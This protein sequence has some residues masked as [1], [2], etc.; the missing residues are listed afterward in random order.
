MFNRI[1]R[2][3]GGAITILSAFVLVAVV[4]VSA[5]AVEF[6]RG[7]YRRIENQR[8]ADIAA[9]SG[10]LAYSVG[11]DY[12]SAVSNIVQ[13]NGLASSNAVP[14]V[15]SSPSGDG[16]YAVQVTVTTSDPLLLARVLSPTMTSLPVSASAMAEVKPS[17]AACIIALNPSGSGIALSG[18]GSI[19][20]PACAIASNSTVCADGGANPSDVITT[21]IIGYD[22]GSPPSSSPCTL[23][24]PTGTTSVQLVKAAIADPLQGSSAVSGATSRLA[25]VAAITSPSVS[26]GT[27]V[28]FDYGGK[29]S[30]TI[31]NL[32]QDG[33]LGV[34]A[35]SVWTVT[36]VGTTSFTFGNFVLQGGI[37]VNFNVLGS[38]N[39]TY[40]FS[41]GNQSCSGVQGYSLCNTGTALNM[42]PGTYVLAGGIYNGGGATLTIGSGS[43]NNSFTI[44]AAGDGNSINVSTS[45]STT[46]GDA[47]GAGDVFQTAGNIVSG[48]GT[49][50]TLSKA[51]EHDINGYISL[52]GG[53][54][55]GDGIWTVTDYVAFGANNGGDVTCNGTAI[56]VSGANIT[57]V[58]GG[59]PTTVTCSG[60]ASAFCVGSGFGHVTL[61]APTSGATANLL[62]IGPTSSSNTAGATFTQGASG[63]TLGGVFYFPH[64]PVSL[65]GA[66]Q[67][68]TPPNACLQLIGS[69][70]TV[71]NGGALGTTCSGVPQAQVGGGA[72]LVN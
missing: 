60:T 71:A 48:G 36:C 45:Q 32:A 11:S 19:D 8:I 66:G 40:Y 35:S 14:A 16:N 67:I 58:I 44:G 61:T 31:A 5:L 49:C 47:T 57:F 2:D 39:V 4:G 23:T 20:A 18:T 62:V 59:A 50:F 21:K 1:F 69:Q 9:Y 15:V 17:A 54:T 13:L 38:S 65:N 28:Y 7:L 43:S 3:K 22:A 64:G 6:G 68:N 25:T 51:A 70:V 46:L 34:L 37:T 33:C 10:A 24:P 41:K 72:V 42:G 55:M 12:T 29:N 56:G 63:T 52:S 30:T 27:D 53:T 26:G